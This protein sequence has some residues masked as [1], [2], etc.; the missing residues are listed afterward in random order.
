MSVNHQPCLS[1]PY[2]FLKTESEITWTQPC[3]LTH[4]DHTQ[5]PQGNI[6]FLITKTFRM[7]HSGTT[8]AESLVKESQQKA[9]FTILTIHMTVTSGT[10]T[11]PWSTKTIST[12]KTSKVH[13]DLDWSKNDLITQK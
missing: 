12:Q 7:I 1:K 6:T 2:N 9:S 8:Q 10:S 4:A 5:Q 3:L 13:H 11:H